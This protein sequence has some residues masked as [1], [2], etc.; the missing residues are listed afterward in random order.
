MGTERG[1]DVVVDVQR[2]KSHMLALTSNGQVYSW[3]ANLRGQLGL[4]DIKP[5]FKPTLVEWFR[6]NIIQ[7]VLAIGN[8]SYAVSDDGL[9]YAWG[10]NLED[11]LAI[12]GPTTSVG[13]VREVLA[14]Q[15]MGLQGKVKR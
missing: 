11:A 9:V 7:Q 13:E 3:G 2:G 14:P 1:E 15:L 6:N 12:S 10:E 8:A 4:G 5:R